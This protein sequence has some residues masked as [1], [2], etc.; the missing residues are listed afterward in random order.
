MRFACTTRKTLLFVPYYPSNL[1]EH[2]RW[3]LLAISSV[4]VTVSTAGGT[5]MGN[6]LIANDKRIVSMTPGE[7]YVKLPSE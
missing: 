2:A 5:V 6:P 4:S 1:G 3:S 7:T